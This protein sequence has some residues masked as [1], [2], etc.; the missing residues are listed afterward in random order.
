M[1]SKNCYQLNT[2]AWV[3]LLVSS[4]V[5][6][7][8]KAATASS[9]PITFMKDGGW[10]WYQDPRAII[11]D[12]KLVIAGLSGQTGDVKVSVYDLRSQKDLGT[13]IL[14]KEFE[15]DDHDVPALYARPDGSILAMWAKHGREKIHYYAISSST[16]YLEWGERQEFH[17]EYEERWGVT[18]MNLYFIEDEELLYNFFRDGKTYNPTYITSTDHGK[19][20][21]NRTH[22]I[23]DE[24]GGRH[25][26]YPRYL[27]RDANT[28]GI[29][30]TEA[31][32]RNFGN[33]IYYADFR[34]GA[35]YRVDGTK[36]KDL[37][38]GPLTPPEAERI[39]QGSNTK[40]KFEGFESVPNSAWTCATVSDADNNPHI[41][42]TLYL[43]NNDHRYRVATW[44][45]NTWVD[46]EIAHAGKYL[47]QKESSY[48]GLMSFNPNDPSEVVISSDV[49]P[50]SGRDFGGTHE[51]YSAKLGRDDDVS[52]IEWEALTKDSEHRNLRPIFVAGEGYEVVIWLSGPWRTY[53]DY[54]SDVVG[55]I[56]SRPN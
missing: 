32:P 13:K 18:Y 25:R 23:A 36:I 54:E 38:E 24:V 22:F 28:V 33:S 8:S 56:L 46:R 16:N 30:F 12:G 43:S 49:D 17:H 29:S 31:H 39:Y 45:G 9:N 14:H 51:I 15:R 35:F 55:V 20:W 37:T 41:G 19:S 6:I 50:S 47:Y 27:Q 21:G 2:Q 44:T 7:V 53:T 11:N 48:T 5:L 26:P 42:Y 34:E 1:S 4:F 3:F 10:C 40:Q 52:S